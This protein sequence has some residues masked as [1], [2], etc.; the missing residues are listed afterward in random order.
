MHRLWIT[1]GSLAG[2]LAVAMSAAA[3]HVLPARLDPARLRLVQSAI[4][5]Q[6]WHA[7]ALVLTGLWVEREHRLANWA[8][9]AF[10]TGTVL[11]CGTLYLLAFTGTRLGL[12]APIGGTLLMA[13]W[14]LLAA[15]AAFGR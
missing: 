12:A 2:L 1:L 13:G 14:A 11:F 10:A 9:G 4:Q 15:S 3:A 6:G 5:M 7:I 8:G